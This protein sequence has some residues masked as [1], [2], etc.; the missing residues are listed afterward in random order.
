M[1]ET[2]HCVVGATSSVAKPLIEK[3]LENNQYVHLIARDIVRLE[4]YEGNPLVSV[5]KADVTNLPALKN[6]IDACTLRMKSLVYLPGT[7]ILKD[8]KSV[9][10][11]ELFEHLKVNTTG[12]LFAAQYAAD[13]L[14]ETK[15]SILFISSVAAQ[16]GF[17]HHSIISLCKA[18]LEGLTVALAK[19][20]A[21]YV[22]VNCIAP[23]LMETKLSG[24]L[25]AN[26]AMK[27]AM[28]KAHPMQR[29]GSP[30]EAAALAYFLIGGSSGWMTGQ[31]IHMD[32]GRGCLD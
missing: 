5:A 8:L 28:A 10:E 26:D 22:R 21:P 12:A 4:V 17:S 16:K 9:S 6:A 31:I 2:C 25:L 20:L 13:I 24:A 7:I 23:S 18:G 14:K 19:E 30:E 3:M 27:K 15:G 32:G 1:Q 11:V 29:L